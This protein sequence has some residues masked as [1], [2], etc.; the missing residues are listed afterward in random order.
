MK[1]RT[2]FVTNS[3]S[4]NTTEVIIDNPVLLEILQK[5]KDMGLFGNRPPI[6]GIGGYESTVR[7]F[8]RKE[9]LEGIRVPAFYYYEEYGEAYSGEIQLVE[10]DYPKSLD[11]VLG[12]IIT[13]LNN[14]KDEHLNKKLCANVIDELEQRKKE[15]ILAY[16]KVR[17]D[18]GLTYDESDYACYRYDCDL[19]ESLTITSDGE[20]ISFIS[21]GIDGVTSDED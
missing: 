18:F 12:S 2:D 19:G 3:S 1:I 6:I 13:I 9:I 5:Y 4:S 17:W 11:E 7:D 14:A 20:S 8:N 21:N 15:I 10:T 16:R